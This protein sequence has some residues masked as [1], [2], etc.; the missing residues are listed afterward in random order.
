MSF[1]NKTVMITGGASGIGFLCGKCFA[2]EGAN[3]VLID[4]NKEALKES[5]NEIK[6]NGKV[7]YS[8]VDV[9]DYEQVI[10]ARELAAREYGGI[11]ILINSA[12]GNEC[13][14][15][16]RREDF[17]D[18]PI[19]VYDWG[20]DVNLKGPFYFAHAVMKKMVEQKSGVIINIG[21]VTGEVGCNRGMAYAAAKSGVMNGLTKSLAL[22][23]SEHNIRV[24]CVSP[25]PVLTRQEM[26]KLKTPL[27]RAAEPQEI[28]DL[29]MYLASEKAAFITGTNFFIDGGRSIRP[30]Q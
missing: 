2:K 27:G 19:E 15:F 7:I 29:I 4:V 23:G 30:C 6:E 12:G 28:V 22:Y 24:C 3:V 14:V 20:I 26:A 16:N 17:V 10:A 25:G 18:I 13:R 5:C 9:R 8:V 11:D 21:S 1:T